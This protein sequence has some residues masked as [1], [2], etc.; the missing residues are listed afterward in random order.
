MIVSWTGD[1]DNK[2]NEIAAVDELVE[3]EA[4]DVVAYHQ[5]QPNVVYAAEEK[6]IYSIGYHQAAQGCSPKHLTAVSCTWE[7]VYEQV[8][9][10][11]LI[12]KG[13]IK[14]N[15]WI[16]LEANAVG[17]STYSEEITPDIITRLEEAT[18]KILA[19]QDVFSGVI[20]DTEGHLRCDEK[21]FISDEKLLE[22][23]DWYV[24]GVRFYER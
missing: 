10:E 13:N 14:E 16:G 15:Y 22:Q 3:M 11:Y 24:E 19:G 9:R 23:M 8:L 6:G 2:E 4:I 17:L 7:L 12:G 21:E 1:W 5:N 20:Y 18:N